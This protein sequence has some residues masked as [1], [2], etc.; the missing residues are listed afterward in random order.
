M[1]IGSP[2][3]NGI[4]IA[5]ILI[6]IFL[7][8][9]FLVR[10][11][12]NIPF[13]DE[14]TF[15]PFLKSF[16]NHEDWVSL[17]FN[18]HN[19]H[20]IVFPK[21]LFLVL[22]KLTDWDI[23]IEMFVSWMLCCFNF[24]LIWLLMRQSGIKSKWILIPVAWLLFSL[25]QW[26]NIIWGWCLHW[27]L[28]I[29]GVLISIYFISKFASSR[30]HIIPAI[31]CGILSSF[32]MNN[33]L[34][35]WPLGIMQ[36]YFMNTELRSK[37][38]YILLWAIIGISILIFY[39][40][41]YSRPSHHPPW[42]NPF[43][44]PLKFLY[45][46]TAQLGL[47]LSGGLVVQAAIIGIFI[48]AVFFGLIFFVKDNK[49]N[50]CQLMPIFILGL[51]S[52]L[53]SAA[54]VIGRMGFGLSYVIVSKYIAISSL[55]IIAS[56]LLL[57][58]VL[59]TSRNNPKKHSIILPLYSA[60]LTVVSIGL[61]TTM[62]VG[63]DWG[64]QSF[65]RRSKAAV[66]LKQIEFAPLH[67]MSYLLCNEE[68]PQIVREKAFFLK[69]HGLS[70]FNKKPE[71]IDL[72]AYQEIKVSSEFRF[73]FIDKVGIIP[74]KD[75][76]TSDDILQIAGWAFDI[77]NKAL[78]KSVFIFCD[79]QLVGEAVLGDPRP[80]IVEATGHNELLMAGWKLFVPVKG[81]KIAGGNHMITA[82]VLLSG[83]DN[84]YRDITKAFK[85]E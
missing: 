55:L 7:Y 82:R 5:G 16:Y 70:T 31:L 8:L 54:I 52:L 45:Y 17:L 72:Q 79:K 66:Y 23:K 24:L 62:F 46:L 73:G 10:F 42:G 83:S 65:E 19:E 6:P 60:L 9:H 32:S 68:P 43:Y 80:D 29:F 53:S 40:S 33:G 28:M 22:A 15:I 64:K 41:D 37:V 44:E 26:E 47:E 59:Q 12:V 61:I 71:K 1:K 20:R 14:W 56:L 84:E 38:K 85:I 81:L 30:W 4:L 78:P 49:E 27:S 77:I 74:S 58:A 2:L 3:K 57:F 36:L 34:L 13:G 67:E 51:F 63:W 25:G 11:G 18:Q 69:S 76:Q 75:A 39:Y 48:L 21:L 35:I 50:F